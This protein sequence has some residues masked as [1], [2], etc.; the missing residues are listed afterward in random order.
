MNHRFP[1][2]IWH[3]LFNIAEHVSVLSIFCPRSA[4]SGTVKN[5][6]GTAPIERIQTQEATWVPIHM[7]VVPAPS[8]IQK[9][10]VLI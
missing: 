4:E 9:T 6:R 2:P 10:K 5:S 7:D 1:I 8:R 3:A